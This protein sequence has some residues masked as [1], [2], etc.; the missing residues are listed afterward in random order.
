MDRRENGAS[1]LVS[2]ALNDRL[3]LEFL[4]ITSLNRS[5]RLLR[6]MMSWRPDAHRRVR[7]GIDVFSGSPYGMFGRFDDSDRIWGEYRYTF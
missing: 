1:L 3:D 6:L 7:A 5:D 2:H 4:G